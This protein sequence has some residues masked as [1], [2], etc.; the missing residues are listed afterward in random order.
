MRHRS[1]IILVV[2]IQGGLIVVNIHWFDIIGLGEELHWLS[3]LLKLDCGEL[4]N[5]L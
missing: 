4:M 3:K 1:T 5:M 2:L